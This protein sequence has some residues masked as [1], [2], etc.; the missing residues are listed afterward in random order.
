MNILFAAIL[1][2]CAAEKGAKS[3][4][5]TRV[6]YDKYIACTMTKD[7]LA[8]S[9]VEVNALKRLNACQ[10]KTLRQKD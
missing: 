8:S 2:I 10:Y 7:V 5:I 4:E 6:C 3:P 1:Q 9:K